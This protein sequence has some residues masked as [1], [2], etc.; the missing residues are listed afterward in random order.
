MALPLPPGTNIQVIYK[1][2]SGDYEMSAMEAAMDHYS[3][4]FILHG[5]RLAITPTMTY[6]LHEGYVGTT[7]PYA[8]LKTIPAS[9]E[10][11]E[12]ILIK[13][14]PEFISPLTKRLGPL[15][16]EKLYGEPLCV[17]TGEARARVFQLA[18]D[19]RTVWE[20]EAEISYKELKLQSMLFIMLMLIYEKG[21]RDE[22][23]SRHNCVLCRPILDAVYYME[24]NYMKPLKIEEVST[25]SGYS[26]SY[27]SRLFQEQLGVS[28]SEYLCNIRLKHVQDALLTTKKSILDIALECGFAYPGNMSS[29][30]KRKLGMTPL[31]YR[32]SSAAV[33]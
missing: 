15:F 3:L 14:S 30:F 9:A 12:N 29:C 22:S 26:V 1:R 18:E 21:E 24:K 19:M 33:P 32:K 16:I 7:P 8:Y 5:D 6:T 27:F 17:F 11:Y 20:E 31:Q 25:A 23:A 28:F 13:F 4:S 2:V 10:Y